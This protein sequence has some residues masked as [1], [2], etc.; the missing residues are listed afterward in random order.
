[1]A[2]HDEKS[3]ELSRYKLSRLTNDDADAYHRVGCPAVAGKLR[4]PL[5]PAL[6]AR[7]HHLPEILEP[8]AIPPPCCTKQS[9]TVPP[10]VNAKTAQ[11]HDYP[12]SAWR[13]SYARRSAAEH[14]NSRP[15]DPAGINLDVRCGCKLL[16]LTPL[17][18]FL[19]CACV[20]V[21][22][23]LVGRRLRGPP[24]RGR[25]PQQPTAAET[26]KATPENPRRPCPD[27]Y[28]RTPH[29]RDQSRRRARHQV[30]ATRTATRTSASPAGR[31][32]RATPRHK[33]H[34]PARRWRRHKREH[35]RGP[36][37]KT[38]RWAVVTRTRTC[39]SCRSASGPCSET[40]TQRG[41]GV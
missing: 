18:L 11:A 36:N 28:R 34:T 38:S 27:R 25:A 13:S 24:G 9:L 23:G 31:C 4:C 16:G 30:S 41:S 8:P 19:A 35:R 14:S 29:S 1:M 22:F 20:I 6:M 37:V 33:S 32:S 26:A 12:S 3:A 7:P 10:A 40:E 39:P 2:A 15:K 21:D 17:A 5:R